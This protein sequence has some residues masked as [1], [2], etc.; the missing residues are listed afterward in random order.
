[1]NGS[2]AS[3]ARV[4]LV[5][6]KLDWA[7]GHIA[8]RIKLEISDEFEVEIF[9]TVTLGGGKNLLRKLSRFRP[10]LVHF[11]WRKELND[12]LSNVSDKAR[13]I[14]YR[15]LLQKT[16]L[17]FSVPDHLYLSTDDLITFAPLFRM[18][19]GYLVTSQKLFDV[20]AN[21]KLVPSPTARIGDFYVAQNSNERQKKD[22]APVRFIWVGNSLWGE[23]VGYSD[24]KG[25]RSIIQPVF[26]RLRTE[27]G[28]TVDCVLID[29]AQRKISHEQVIS[30]LKSSDV[31]LCASQAE[32]TPLPL[33]EAMEM[34]CAIITTDVGIASEVLPS[35]QSEFIIDRNEEDFY[36]AAV[37]MLSDQHQMRRLQAANR[38]KFEAMNGTGIG[39]EW[40]S[41][42]HA[43]LKKDNPEELKRAR[44]NFNP[45]YSSLS[46]VISHGVGS[47]RLL[48]I[49][50]RI[51]EPNCN[52]RV[53]QAIESIELRFA[54]CT[55]LR[56][57]QLN[58]E[59]LYIANPKW[60]GVFGSTENLANGNLLPYPMLRWRDPNK[61]SDQ[62]LEGVAAIICS[63]TPQQVLFS[64]GE[65]YQRR[66]AEIIKRK[67]SKVQ[68]GLLWHGQ[69]AQWIYSYERDVFHE[70]LVALDA[71]VVRKIGVFKESLESILRA[72]GYESYRLSNY[73]SDWPELAPAH[74]VSNSALRIGLWSA[75]HDWRKNI[76]TQLVAM[77][78]LP[79]PAVVHHSFDAPDISFVMKQFGIADEKCGAGLL[80]R[81][82][83]LHEMSRTDL[84]LYV[85]LGECSPMTPLESISMN[86]PA[87]VGPVSDI[88][89]CD[90]LL[91]ST[92]IVPK[93][94]TPNSISDAIQNAF[95]RRS[96]LISRREK[97]LSE[98]REL[99][100]ERLGIF[101]SA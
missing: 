21:N 43:I 12:I 91:R 71:G 60:P 18:A 4:A 67:S 39:L 96:E 95:H 19:S 16:H 1:M 2:S 14:K 25:V 24:Y 63:K 11:F 73:L 44:F 70:W 42:V 89:D 10:D 88:Y 41:F 51:S 87:L 8:A 69:L 80:R 31:L 61:I 86:S 27:Y 13:L 81:E 58:E 93:P 34:G 40:K 100:R 54:E 53:Q 78:L 48:N 98:T 56:M 55:M 15:T 92:L 74:Q 83:L 45:G 90:D 22:V 9:E 79:W 99:G 82:H 35:M 62:E 97:F 75:S 30:I 26:D 64:G 7:F 3:L 101:L 36:Q 59:V 57:D 72:R 76:H 66:L 32:G 33:L 46:E 47:Q 29:A 52:Y 20:Y 94:E 6:D 38:Q 5:V 85:T 84:T 37:K 50:R 28:N 68:V 17:T 65:R 23:W 49:V 77:A